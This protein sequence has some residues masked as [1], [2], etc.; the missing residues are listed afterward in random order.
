MLAWL[1]TQCSNQN[2]IQSPREKLVVRFAIPPKLEP[3]PQPEL[4]K[5]QLSDEEII[6]CYWRWYGLLGIKLPTG[7]DKYQL[8]VGSIKYDE[9]SRTFRRSVWGMPKDG[10]SSRIEMVF[11][12]TTGA[13]Y[14][15]FNYAVWIKLYKLPAGVQPTKTKEEIME[16]AS[17]YQ[18]LIIGELANN[19][20]I[21]LKY[22]QWESRGGGTNLK[23]YW[24]ISWSRIMNSYE[25][26][27]DVCNMS[28]HEKYGL[29]T[30][31]FSMR[32][33]PCPTDIK[34]TEDQ[35]KKIASAT[36]PIVIPKLPHLP[37]QFKI[38][39]ITEC[40]LYIINPTYIFSPGVESIWTYIGNRHTR[41]AYRIAFW[42]EGEGKNQD[43]K[44]VIEVDAATG[45]ILG[46]DYPK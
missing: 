7:E 26:L 12:A 6:Q 23:G 8:E 17:K 15:L 10:K 25:T 2:I 41:L 43:F 46:G 9:D 16:A 20:R 38:K 35:A 39:K 33:L 37:Q 42:M 22:S 30:F 11:D 36:V 14:G 3:E 34:I 19:F 28:I 32:S 1:L 45:E 27:G 21:S 40:N 29:I 4:P 24:D 5:K 13:L 44:I 31:A 18:R